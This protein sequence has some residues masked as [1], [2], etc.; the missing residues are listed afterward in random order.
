MKQDAIIQ[1]Q[2]I[3]NIME[4]GH[5]AAT[6]L[7]CVREEMTKNCDRFQ[8]EIVERRKEISQHGEEIKR[9]QLILAKLKEY[10]VS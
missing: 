9:L 8:T 4:L 5:L 3:L 2:I 1:S 10:G 6:D 7:L